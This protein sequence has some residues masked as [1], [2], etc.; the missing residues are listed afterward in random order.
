MGKGGDLSLNH[1]AAMLRPIKV[2]NRETIEVAD[3][4]TIEVDNIDGGRGPYDA[5]IE[6]C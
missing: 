5:I 3:I 6:K 1:E 4:E 2:A